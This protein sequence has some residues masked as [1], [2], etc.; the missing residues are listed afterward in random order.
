LDNNEELKPIKKPIYKAQEYERVGVVEPSQV[1]FHISNALE[2]VSKK[3]KVSI[4]GYLVNVQSIRLRTF[5]LTGL[6]CNCCGLEGSYFAIERTKGNDQAGFHLNLWAKDKSGNEIL[7]THDHIHARGL[8]GSDDT[9]N[10]ET[11]CGPCNWEKGQ[12]EQQ[13]SKNPLD[14]DLQK[15]IN[16]FK[17]NKRKNMTVPIPTEKF[18]KDIEAFKAKINEKILA[19]KSNLSP[20]EITQLVQQELEAQQALEVVANDNCILRVVAGSHSYGTNIPSSDWDER[21]IFTDQMNRVILPFD[22]IE[23]VTF[24]HD[25]IVYFELSKYMPLL[26]AQN[27]NVL[28][29]LWTDPDDILFKNEMGQLLLDNRHNFLCSKVKDSYVGYATGQLKRI[30][31]HNKWLNN[32]QPEKEPEPKDFVSVVYNFTKNTAFNKTSPSEGYVALSLGDNHYALWEAES[33][34]LSKKKSWTDKR[35][36]PNAFIQSEFAKININNSFPALIVKVNAKLFDESHTNWKSYW[37]W[38]KNRNDKRSEL[39]ALH[40]Y[41]TKHAMHLIRLLRSG[42]DILETGIVPVKRKDA[43]YLLDIRNGK[44]TYEEIV[45]ESERLSAK[46][47]ELSKT[48]K[49]PLEPNFQL[50][51]DLMLDIYQQQWKMTPKEVKKHKP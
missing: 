35:G 50:G 29:L 21:G 25:D 18:E 6:N 49:L 41:D 47:E 5:L 23:Q 8:G 3:G 46:V 4:N 43:D 30:K 42:V 20:E 28:E 14:S 39:E 1:L 19:S 9:T 33:L 7:M 11:M 26:L 12:L 51:K 27:P 36:N 24:L 32:P 13:L 16:T 31:G 44:Y 48:T 45:T 10:T 15:K 34:N 22:K 37:N 2:H 38:K 40:G 17:N